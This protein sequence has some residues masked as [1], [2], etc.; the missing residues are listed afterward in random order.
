MNTKIEATE[1]EAVGIRTTVRQGING[2]SVWCFV[3]HLLYLVS[4]VIAVQISS[5]QMEMQKQAAEAARGA[6]ATY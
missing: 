2:E 1:K 6:V 5:M 4:L 3:S